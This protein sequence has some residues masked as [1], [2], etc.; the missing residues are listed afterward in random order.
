MSAAAAPPA[1]ERS[2]RLE[3]MRVAAKK[4]PLPDRAAALFERQQSQPDELEKDLENHLVGLVEHSMPITSQPGGGHVVGRMLG[5]SRY[6]GTAHR[7]WIFG[8][9]KDGRFGRVAVPYSRTQKTGWIRLSGMELSRT[10][11]S[12]R[13]DLSRHVIVVKHLDETIMTLSAA[14]GASASPTPPGRYFVTDRVPFEGGYLGTFA[15]GLS[16]IQ[17]NLPAGWSGGDQLAVHGTNNPDSI[18]TSASAGC[19]R[20]SERS[21]DRLKPILKLGTPVTIQP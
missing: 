11:Y 19:L 1:D 2:N 10:P 13:A 14:T 7:A 20:V 16:G 17:P 21:L 15:F 12:V 9:T 5:G 6:Y 8:Q 18:G 4:V 3:A